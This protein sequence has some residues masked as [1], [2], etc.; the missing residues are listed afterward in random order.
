[1]APACLPDENRAD[2]YTVDIINEAAA[3]LRAGRLVAFPTETVYGLGAYAF[4]EAAIR[5]VY[6]VKGRPSDNPLIIH[7]ENAGQLDLLTSEITE[8]VKRL[9]DRFWPGP[10]TLIFKRRA[11]LP[12][13]ATAGL[14]TVAVRMPSHPVA[15]AL[16]K[17]AG[18]PVSAPSANPSGKPSPTDGKH[19]IEDLTGKIDMIIDSG[20]VNIGLESTVLDV[21]RT[22]AVILR[23]GGVTRESIAE[24]IG[25]E[26]V[27][28]WSEPQSGSD[29]EPQSGSDREPQSGSD[30]EPQSGSDREPGFRP[31]SPGMKYR[32]YAPDA[33]MLLFDGNTKNVVLWMGLYI[34][35]NFKKDEKIGV[36][37]T[38]RVLSRLGGKLPENAAALS[39][40]NPDMP[41]AAAR[42]LYD[43]L[44][45]FD[46]IG[47]T[48]I[49]G[50][51]Y[52][53]GGIGAAVKDRM[54]RASGA[55]VI[56][57]D[58]PAI[59]FVCS[60]NT[61]R[62]AMAEALFNSFP[63]SPRSSSAGIYA[64]DGA[65]ATFE[66]INAMTVFGADI[67]GHRSRRLDYRLL[68]RS[69]VVLTMTGAHKYEILKRYPTMSTRVFT[70][71]DFAMKL[72]PEENGV[73]VI[74]DIEDPFGLGQEE[75]QKCAEKLYV[76]AARLSAA[77]GR[78]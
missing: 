78:K 46:K 54:T 14:E 35:S 13:C 75:Y 61:C 4:D 29:R 44:R 77:T 39:L 51:L 9:I 49:Y 10:L 68:E 12:I 3:L 28:L 37:A 38:D 66:A 31:V 18:V 22:P 53:G 64:T 63:Q 32:H 20:P 8:P 70:Y 25:A 26:N 17:A 24:V 62:S 15:R 6:N 59:L 72:P 7:I 21:S 55:N 42:A 67:T 41:E 16:L 69:G 36:L 71:T 11:D 40:G 47:V 73:A 27:I 19:V 23:P 45:A 1:M 50:E 2:T 34:Q 57:A 56:N 60:G 58:D 52:G 43:A 74:G 76:L 65:M 5:E 48:K 33:P 30:R